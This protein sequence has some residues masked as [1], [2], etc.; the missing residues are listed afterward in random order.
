MSVSVVSPVFIGRRHE[1]AS[2]AAPLRRVEG[3]EP[4]R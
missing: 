2:L 4:S 1:I 3:G